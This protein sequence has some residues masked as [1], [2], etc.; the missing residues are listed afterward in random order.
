MRALLGFS[1]HYASGTDQPFVLV[2]S[3][4]SAIDS[5]ACIGRAAQQLVHIVEEQR[6][7]AC[8]A[9][10]TDPQPLGK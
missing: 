8:D 6:H 9:S 7:S 10:S 1:H 5:A 3:T 2:S 4:E